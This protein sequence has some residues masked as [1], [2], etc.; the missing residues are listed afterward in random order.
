MCID[1]NKAESSSTS[2]LVNEAFPGMVIITYGEK[3][4]SSA[5]CDLLRLMTSTHEDAEKW[6]FAHASDGAQHCMKKI[7]LRTVDMDV[8]II[9]LAQKI[10]CRCLWLTFGTGTIFQCLIPT[11]I[12]QALGNNKC[13]TPPAFHA[14]TGCDWERICLVCMKSPQLR[15]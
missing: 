9:S 12:A 11:T 13:I 7:L 5:P 6:M 14:L 15:D 4:F 10:G 3:V 1:D 8:V 2:C